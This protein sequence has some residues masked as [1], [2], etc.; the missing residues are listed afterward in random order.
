V[1]AFCTSFGFEL[2]ELKWGIISG[3]G[4]AGLRVSAALDRA[5]TYS[6][7]YEPTKIL[8][9]YRRKG[10]YEDDSKQRCGCK[11]FEGNSIKELREAMIR[12]SKI[13]VAIGGERGTMQE[14]QLAEQKALPVIPIAMTGGTALSMWEKVIDAGEFKHDKKN[15]YFLNYQILIL[16]RP[17]MQLLSLLLLTS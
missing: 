14:L 9:F 10:G 4:K 15:R 6:N 5:L 3:G 12:R 11:L 1:D 7:L 8:T 16:I 13:I 17:L 2:A